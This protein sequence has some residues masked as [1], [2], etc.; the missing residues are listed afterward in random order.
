MF[1]LDLH[2]K[3]LCQEEILVQPYMYRPSTRERGNTWSRTADSLNAIGNP[4]CYVNQ[5][6]FNLILT[7]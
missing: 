4:Q 6:R 3:L 5:R 7:R 2:D 1:W